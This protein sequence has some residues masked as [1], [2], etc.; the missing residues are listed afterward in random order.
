MVP[1]NLHKSRTLTN[2][3]YPPPPS[4]GPYPCL[5]TEHLSP[6][7]S[8]P[9]GV[10]LRRGECACFF[11]LSEGGE[12]G[13]GG[14]VGEVYDRYVHFPITNPRAPAERRGW[15]RLR[16]LPSPS[17]SSF[18][19]F[20]IFLFPI[21]SSPIYLS[22]LYHRITL[23]HH[24]PSYIMLSPKQTYF[25]LSGLAYPVLYRLS[26]LTAKFSTLRGGLEGRVCS[27]RRTEY[28]R[29]EGEVR[30]WGWGW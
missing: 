11:L 24:V 1:D 16:L 25:T 26:L 10:E 5:R 23:I 9:P 6:P 12:R 13:I 4:P 2:S 18:P 8:F 30:V 22:P 3:F 29:G 14:G 27:L 17:P 21:L 15:G 20:S 19:P 28:G 7:R